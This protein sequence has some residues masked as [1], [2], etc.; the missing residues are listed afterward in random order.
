[1]VQQPAI[2]VHLERAE[3]WCVEGCLAERGT[4]ILKSLAGTHL[5]A[6]ANP[7]R[8]VIDS[9]PPEHVGL[10]TGTQL[11]LAIARGV[12]EASGF[13]SRPAVELAPLVGR[14]ARS[15]IGVHGFDHGGFLVDGGKEDHD[16]VA[17]LVSSLTFPDEWRIV[18]AIPHHSSGVFG[19]SEFQAFQ[20]LVE[21]PGLTDALCRC[22]LLQLLP[23]LS[24]ADFEGVAESL[25]W[26][27]YSAGEAFRSIQGGAYS[28]ARIEELIEH[29]RQQ[30]VRC[31]GQTSWGPTVFAVAPDQDQ[32]ARI[33]R[34]CEAF[35][36]L[37]KERVM[38]TCAENRGA[39]VAHV[40]AR[41][42][43]TCFGT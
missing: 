27:N 12:A 23:A 18:L 6:E 34:S 40:G 42:S 26:F 14:G 2:E 32:A 7:H 21:M 37:S 33:A 22:V 28:S 39:R 20:D 36:H 15:A 19:T 31:V 9:A 8:V 11:A 25:H 10:G 13:V 5:L 29:L 16:A 30:G 41:V 24:A 43:K 3:C 1:M 4:A 38:I 35:P 17:P